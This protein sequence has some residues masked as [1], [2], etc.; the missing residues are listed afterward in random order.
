LQTLTFLVRSF[1]V[2]ISISL[3]FDKTDHKGLMTV[4]PLPCAHYHIAHECQHGVNCNFGHKAEPSSEQFAELRA[5]AKFALPCPIISRGDLLLFP[6]FLSLKPDLLVDNICFKHE[7][8]NFAHICPRGPTCDLNCSFKGRK[9]K[10]PEH[11][12]SEH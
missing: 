9:L 8:C 11:M 7:T 12:H 6:I 10:T 4:K 3:P 5:Y 1:C 2:N